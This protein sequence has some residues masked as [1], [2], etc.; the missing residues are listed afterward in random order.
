MGGTRISESKVSERPRSVR[1]DLKDE[2][3]MISKRRPYLSQFSC[4]TSTDNI[5]I[6]QTFGGRRL[7]NTSNVCRTA[8]ENLA[9]IG[10]QSG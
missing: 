9:P 3:A 10:V 5:T 2:V 1:M 4:A 8:L 6:G 7:N